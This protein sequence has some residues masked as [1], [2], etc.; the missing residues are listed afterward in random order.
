MLS[1]LV[2]LVYNMDPLVWPTFPRRESPENLLLG[3][4]QSRY[5]IEVDRVV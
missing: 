4:N 5:N 2:R 3:R 1:Y